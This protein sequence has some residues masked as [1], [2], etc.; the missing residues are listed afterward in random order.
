M[1]QVIH[2]VASHLYNKSSAL[3]PIENHQTTGKKKKKNEKI[4]SVTPSVERDR[5]KT[6]ERREESVAFVGFY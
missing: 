2:V 4:S 5:D 3:S 1:S 6:H